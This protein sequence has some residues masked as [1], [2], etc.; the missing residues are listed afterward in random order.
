M[1]SVVLPQPVSDPSIIDS[2]AGFIHEVIP[3]AY[4]SVL[5]GDSRESVVR[6]RFEQADYND[7]SLY[8]EAGEDCDSTPPLLLVLGYSNGVQVWSIGSSGEAVEVLSWNQR[9]VRTLRFLPSPHSS[10][11][12]TSSSSSPL[13]SVRA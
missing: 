10:A 3:Q 9:V 12:T 4:S 6:A 8:P 13:G 7:P 1:S 2:V 11:Y 5:P